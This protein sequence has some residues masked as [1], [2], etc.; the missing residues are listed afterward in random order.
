VCVSAELGLI[1]TC[2]FDV[3]SSQTGLSKIANEFFFIGFIKYF[4]LLRIAD[5]LK[6]LLN[7]FWFIAE[8]VASHYYSHIF[9]I[10]S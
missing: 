2:L 1:S 8:V 4:P 10:Q 7:G 5:L 6:D 3:P 9:N